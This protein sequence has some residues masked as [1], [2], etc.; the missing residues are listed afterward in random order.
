LAWIARPRRRAP[1]P[2][3]LAGFQLSGFPLRPCLNAGWVLKPQGGLFKN[4]EQ[5]SWI[6]TIYHPGWQA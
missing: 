3:R 6:E 4:P 5:I 2:P 1:Q